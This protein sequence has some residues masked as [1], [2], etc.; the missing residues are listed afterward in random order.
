MTVVRVHVFVRSV[1]I[2]KSIGQVSIPQAV[3]Y[4]YNGIRRLIGS[5]D[6]KASL[7][8]VIMPLFSAVSIGE[9]GFL[10]IHVVSK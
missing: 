2:V 7:S 5:F 3:Y 1:I 6:L 10:R 9:I 4:H 8:F